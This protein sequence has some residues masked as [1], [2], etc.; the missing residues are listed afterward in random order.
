MCTVNERKRVYRVSI[1]FVTKVV[2]YGYACIHNYENVEFVTNSPTRHETVIDTQS[3]NL[4][5]D[6][7]YHTVLK[8]GGGYDFIFRNSG[9]FTGGSTCLYNTETNEMVSVLKDMHHLNHNFCVFPSRCGTAFYGIGG[10]HFP[11]SLYGGTKKDEPVIR[12]RNS[13]VISPNIYS[14]YH[15]NGLYLMKSADMFHWEY[16]KKLPIISGIHVGHT[17]NVFDCSRF[18]SKICCFYSEILQQYILFI[19]ANIGKGRRWIQTTR[20]KDLVHWEPFE[21]LKMK[22]VDF[23]N[24][25][26]YHLD[27]ME[28]PDADLFIGVSAYTNKPR[29]PTKSCIKLMF[30]KDGVHWVD[31]GSILDTPASADGFRNSVQTTSVFFDKGEYYDMFFNENYDGVLDATESST[32]VNYKIPKDRLVGISSQDTGRFEF[33][34]GVQSDHLVFNYDCQDDGYISITVHDSPEEI[35]LYGNEC[36]KMVE[37]GEEYIHQNI[38]IRVEMRNSVLYSC[39][40]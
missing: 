22:G 40:S 36:N 19:R 13:F 35:I 27:V 21:L 11:P 30:S 23:D 34:I 2:F 32:V 39:S 7:S 12:Y 25:N 9:C 4:P 24:D 33:E 31:R 38:R 10:M 5:V 37:I 15:R 14:R 17:D 3:L 18:D 29:Y 26:Y 16:V 28:Y 1:R 8:N 20:S 6:S